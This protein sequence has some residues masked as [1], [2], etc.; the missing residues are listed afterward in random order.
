MSALA[1]IRWIAVNGAMAFAVYFGAIAGVKWCER[2]ALF[3]IWVM[4][5]LSIVVSRGASEDEDVRLML[6]SRP[7]WFWWVDGVYDAAMI[8]TMA[9]VGW[10][11]TALAW[12]ANLCV[13]QSAAHSAR[14]AVASGGAK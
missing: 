11:W 9:A 4:A 13:W 6:S 8:L 1:V 14:K 2:V 7:R 5:A 12:L 10:T 3:V